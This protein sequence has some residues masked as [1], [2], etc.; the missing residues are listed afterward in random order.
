MGLNKETRLSW[1]QRDANE[2]SFESPYFI[3][4]VIFNESSIDNK[5][6]LKLITCN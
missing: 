4:L 5:L 2:N 6:L 1:A 3:L